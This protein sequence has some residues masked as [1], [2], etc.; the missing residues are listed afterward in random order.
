VSGLVAYLSPARI[1]PKMRLARVLLGVRR[2]CTALISTS[3]L[4]PIT[5]YRCT[6]HDHSRTW[7]STGIIGTPF[8]PSTRRPPLA[9]LGD[10]IGP[11]LIHHNA[12]VRRDLYLSR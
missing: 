1:F 2:H 9:G 12:P 5:P 7:R 8:P 10:L 3:L 4:L 11:Q 6:S